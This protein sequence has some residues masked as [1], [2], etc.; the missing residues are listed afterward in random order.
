MGHFLFQ[1]INYGKDTEHLK[2]VFNSQKDSTAIAYIE[3]D[4]SLI[5][6]Y[7]MMKLKRFCR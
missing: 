4:T 3:S 5:G 7:Q 6:I 1:I 2:F